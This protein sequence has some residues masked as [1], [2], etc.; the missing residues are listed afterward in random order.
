MLH[1]WLN[2]SL[3]ENMWFDTPDQCCCLLMIGY[4]WKQV[5][6]LQNACLQPCRSQTTSRVQKFWFF[7]CRPT[8]KLASP[9]FPQQKANGIFPLD[10]GSLQKINS[11]GNTSLW[12]LQ[13]L[14]RRI[15]L[16]NEHHLYDVWS[17]NAVTK[18]QLCHGNY[19]CTTNKAWWRL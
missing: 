16:T 4:H 5:V 9:C 10:F 18:A 17:A 1:F 7:F 15:F 2:A 6:I 11:V 3:E 8:G 14:L 19:I 13:V 12:F